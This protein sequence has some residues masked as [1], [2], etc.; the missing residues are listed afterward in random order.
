MFRWLTAGLAV[1]F[2]LAS[3]DGDRAPTETDRAP[4]ETGLP[5][6]G[7]PAGEFGASRFGA[8]CFQ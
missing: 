5:D 6:P 3:C 4:L 2:A 7:C 1:V 8:S